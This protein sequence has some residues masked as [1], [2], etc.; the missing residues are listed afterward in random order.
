MIHYNSRAICIPVTPENISCKGAPGKIMTSSFL[1]VGL[2]LAK[3]L[4]PSVEQKFAIIYQSI[5]QTRKVWA[6]E[7]GDANDIPFS[8][9][10]IKM[11]RNIPV[12]VGTSPGNPSFLDLPG[13][14]RTR[15]TQQKGG[16][17]LKHG[18]SL[19]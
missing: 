6:G 16:T 14:R 3:G 5:S 12:L 4:L 17:A 8:R 2:R 15:A 1:S 11:C 19:H 13:M 18:F 9:K 7:R 10:G